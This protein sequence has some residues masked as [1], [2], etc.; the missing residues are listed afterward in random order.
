[1]VWF[2]KHAFDD[3]YFDAITV[4][5][6]VRNFE[7]LDKGLKEILR[8]LKPNGVF[9]NSRNISTWQNPYKQGY[10]FYS[11]ISYHHR[12]TFSKM[13]YMAT[14]QNQLLHFLMEKLWT[15]YCENWVYRCDSLTTDIWGS[16]HLAS[17]TNTEKYSAQTWKNCCLTFTSFIH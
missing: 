6:G 5:F 1:M 8:V 11:K 2:R 17:K 14:C 7:T 4:A 9:C 3:N 13:M 10:N 15:I 12:Q 16:Y